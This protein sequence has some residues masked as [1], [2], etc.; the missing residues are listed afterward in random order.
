MVQCFSILKEIRKKTLKLLYFVL[1][2]FFGLLSLSATEIQ[3][4]KEKTVRPYISFRAV[5]WLY[6]NN[7]GFEKHDS[8]R[9]YLIDLHYSWV[10]K[11]CWTR[12]DLDPG[13]RCSTSPLCRYCFNFLLKLKNIYVIQVAEFFIYFLQVWRQKSRKILITANS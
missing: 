7:V 4:G 2:S 3:S 10:Y 1:R 6:W 11:T 9:R 8:N 12:C 13:G 5:S